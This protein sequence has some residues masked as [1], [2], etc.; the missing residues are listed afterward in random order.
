MTSL[1]IDSHIPVT[2]ARRVGPNSL[3]IRCPFCEKLHIHGS[4]GDPGPWYGYYRARC[5]PADLPSETRYWQRDGYFLTLTAP[6]QQPD[7]VRD[8]NASAQ[9]IPLPNRE[10]TP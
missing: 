7:R 6:P 9:I 8:R 5:D 1:F 2:R 10:T 4:G 3:M